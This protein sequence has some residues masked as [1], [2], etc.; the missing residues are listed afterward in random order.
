MSEMGVLVNENC[1]SG[2]SDYFQVR[3]NPSAALALSI[4]EWMD[5]SA[6]RV[7]EKRHESIHWWHQTDAP[8]P[9]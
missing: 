1:P 3:D 2:S 4:V 9:L 8:G 6:Q 7:Q 5:F